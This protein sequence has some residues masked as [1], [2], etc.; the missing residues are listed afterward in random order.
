MADVKTIDFNLTLAQ[1]YVLDKYLKTIADSVEAIEAIE[2]RP[3]TAEEDLLIDALS[4]LK[5][6]LLDG[7]NK[8]DNHEVDIQRANYNKYY[9]KEL[10]KK[11]K[12]N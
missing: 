8:V 6:Q 12:E 5:V 3:L 7:L 1:A 2:V 4:W 9:R 10:E 11:T